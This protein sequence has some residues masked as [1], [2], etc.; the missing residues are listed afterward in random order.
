MAGVLIGKGSMNQPT[1]QG[2]ADEKMEKAFKDKVISKVI[3][4]NAKDLQKCYFNLL[5]KKPS[6]TEGDI[7]ILIHLEE[8]GKVSSAEL[9]KNTLNDS[10]F[11]DCVVKKVESYYFAP[12]PI[13]INRYISHTLSF[14]SEE[15]AL[16][17]A[18]E[19]AEAS[20]PPQMLPVKP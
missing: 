13:G 15:T 12:P 7:D 19:R 4:E 2:P 10:Q 9:T 3:R 8:N 17:E 5:D 11:G 14:K 18:K 1:V 6:V 16:R 20:K